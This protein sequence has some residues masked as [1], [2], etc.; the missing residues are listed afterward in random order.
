MVWNYEV[1]WAY[2]RFLCDIG[3][4]NP[5]D[6]ARKMLDRANS[7]TWVPGT[8]FLSWV[9]YNMH[10]WFNRRDPYSFVIKA[11]NPVAAHYLP[12]HIYKRISKWEKN[13]RVYSM[14]MYAQ[15]PTFTQKAKIDIFFTIGIQLIYAPNG[16]NLQPM[17]IEKFSMDLCDIEDII[18]DG[19]VLSKPEGKYYKGELIAVPSTTKDFFSKIILLEKERFQYPD[20]Q[21]FIATKDIYCNR[22]KRTVIHKGCAYGGFASIITCSNP[23]ISE[24]PEQILTHLVK[25]IEEVDAGEKKDIEDRHEQLLRMLSK[26]LN[27]TYYQSKGWIELNDNLIARSTPA[28]ILK[29][30]LKE[31]LEKGRTQF[32]QKELLRIHEISLGQKD[33]NLSTRI[34]RL[35]HKINGLDIDLRLEKIEHGG[36]ELQSHSKITLTE[37]D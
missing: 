12:N 10:K 25:D 29:Y 17:T 30:F 14:V 2:E 20:A 18:W 24:A 36:I 22:R 35:I 26:A 28:K 31:W 19:T 32:Q 4:E 34:S 1:T 33:P 21:L 13:D 16:F 6:I 37:K 5:S 15:E 11:L 3:I 23:K 8:K 27:F 9:Y 7:A